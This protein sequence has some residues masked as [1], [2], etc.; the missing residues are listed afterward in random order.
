MDAREPYQ[1]DYCGAFYMEVK[2][3]KICAKAPAK[4][5]PMRKSKK[6]NVAQT[7]E[8]RIRNPQVIGST[9]VVSTKKK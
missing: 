7:G 3:H 1:C 6:A 4:E 9:P 8:Q 5:K 2:E